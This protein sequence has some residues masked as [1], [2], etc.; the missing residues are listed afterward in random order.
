MMNGEHITRDQYK[1]RLQRAKAFE[2]GAEVTF[3]GTVEAKSEKEG[4][5]ASIDSTT[6][7]TLVVADHA[8]VIR[9][10]QSVYY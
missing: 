6:S 10:G 8:S 9:K 2:Q 4:E 7:Y 1:Q 3:L 5:K